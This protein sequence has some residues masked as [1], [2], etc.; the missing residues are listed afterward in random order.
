M[1]QYVRSFKNANAGAA[2]WRDLSSPPA[3]NDVAVNRVPLSRGLPK[4]AEE[5]E[6]LRATLDVAQSSDLRAA[7]L[8]VMLGLG[9]H[10]RDIV[11]LDVSDVVQVGSV[12]CVRVASR[13]A[14]D[15]GQE[16][17]LPV[18]GADARTLRGYLAQQHDEAADEASPLFYNIEH[19]QGDR[20]KR[21]TANA[22][23]YWLLEL[24]LRAR[25]AL[26]EGA[27]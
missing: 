26:A 16:S 19:G 10:K 5:I 6:L 25:Q 24:R 17:F 13:R 9:L 8:L 11:Q 4:D 15:K 12:V 21:I 7:A 14:S 22:V 2:S 20:L 23:S 3:A 27:I 18:I 1:T